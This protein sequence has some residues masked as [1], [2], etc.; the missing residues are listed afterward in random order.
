MA[1]LF[2]KLDVY[3][4]ALDW[5]GAVDDVISLDKKRI[6]P[7]FRDQLV[8]AALSISLNI[9]EGN[10]RWHKADKQQFFRVARGSI[11]ECVAVI[12]ALYKK[13][14]IQEATYQQAYSQLE[15]LSKMLSGLISSVENRP[16][17]QTF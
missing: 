6:S 14:V 5:I 8:R 15:T 11:F 4:K 7:P 9:A 13:G 3:V 16:Q 12:Q 1:F 2:E 10:G 17:H